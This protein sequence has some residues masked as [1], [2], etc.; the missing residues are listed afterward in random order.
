MGGCDFIGGYH[1]NI[2]KLWIVPKELPVLFPGAGIFK[3][4]GTFLPLTRGDQN[5]LGPVGRGETGKRFTLS[6]GK[7][8]LHHT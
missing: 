4:G 7:G 1:S 5:C 8:F 3:S 6:E 2:N